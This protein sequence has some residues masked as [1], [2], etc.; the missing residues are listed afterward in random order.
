L[1]STL[2]YDDQSMLVDAAQGYSK[3]TSF[4]CSCHSAVAVEYD[5]QGMLVD[6][7]QVI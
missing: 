2:R 7:A 6:A 4:T 5:D 3:N 1:L